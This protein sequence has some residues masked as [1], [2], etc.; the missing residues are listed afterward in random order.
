MI[1]ENDFIRVAFDGN[2]LTE[3]VNRKTGRSIAR[4][5]EFLRLVLGTPDYLEF[6]VTHLPPTVRGNSL[7]FP[8]FVD[9]AGRVWEIEAE[10]G[11][12]LDGDELIWQVA[13]R[14]RTETAT[15]R[16]CHCPVIAIRDP[17]PPMA[18]VTSEDVSTR[19]ADLPRAMREAFTKYMAADHKM[20]RRNAV[21]PGRTCSLNFFELEWPD[22]IFYYGC[23]DPEFR[24][25]VHSFEEDK[26]G[27]NCFMAQLP[28]TAPG[29]EWHA[30][31]VVTAVCAGTW[32]KGPEKYRAW[33]N[34]WWTPPPVPD[35]IRKMA[36]WQRLIMRHQYGERFFGYDD[37]PR[38]YEEGKTAGLDTIFLFGWTAEGMDS[39]YPVY[40]P[41]PTQGGFENLRRN[42]RQVQARGGRLILYF[43]GQLI[44]L[45]TDYYRSGEGARVAIKRGDGSEHREFYNFSNTGTYLREFGNKTFTVACPSCRSWIE[46]LK[47]HIDFTAELGADAVFFDQLGYASPPCCDPSHG[48][49]VPFTGLMA[50]KREMAR[51]LYCYA[52]DR[53]LAFGLECTTDQTAEFTDF[54]HICGNTAQCWNPDW[55]ERG[56]P[57][58]CKANSYLF[59]AAFPETVIS[60]REIRDDS[61]VEFPVNR[62]ILLGS[63]SD[64]EIYRCRAG[65]IETP[66]YRRYLGQANAL[67][68]K[69][70]DLL[71]RGRFCG[72]EFHQTDNPECQ[73][74]GFRQGDRLAVIVT[75][76]HRERL[77]VTVT[78]PGGSLLEFDSIRRDA[79]LDGTKV[80]LPRHSLAVLV[81]CIAAQQM[82]NGSITEIS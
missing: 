54:I 4:P 61:D 57:P 74:N 55:A 72:S 44:D 64:V 70:G 82:E 7:F 71:Y 34:T 65:I 68:E 31:P 38:L 32:L 73:T 59:K 18:A 39:G 69:F 49:P 79:E 20:I 11:L 81:F 62:M 2:R 75:Q 21:Y 56:V 53:G 6:T 12:E 8:G 76:S 58:D 51:E 67:R 24:Y 19:I 47:R 30:A 15:V 22:E 23:H 50:A 43:N 3:L 33:A 45:D 40:T 25:T 63:R 35:F 52:H 37:L 46:I 5:R 9:D 14:N 1:L 77:T 27:I 16:E 60:N 36:G 26:T 13:L 17:A 80:T 29:A 10:I 42:I 28:F 66:D 48:H 41:D 78:V